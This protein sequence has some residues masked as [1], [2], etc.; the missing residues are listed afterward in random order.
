[1]VRCTSVYTGLV[2]YILF[3]GMSPRSRPTE[4]PP[5][6]RQHIYQQLLLTS[7]QHQLLLT[8]P[9]FVKHRGEGGG[10]GG[11]TKKQSS[12]SIFDSRVCFCDLVVFPD[13]ISNLA[14]NASPVSTFVKVMHRSFKSTTLLTRVIFRASEA[15]IGFCVT[16]PFAPTTSS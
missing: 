15:T 2:P 3:Q 4:P 5:N 9:H 8:T 6:N 16:A 14:A 7:R 13:I 10:G 12:Q 11:A 1:M